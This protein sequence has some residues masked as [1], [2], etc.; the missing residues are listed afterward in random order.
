MK[1]SLA[2]ISLLGLCACAT[3]TDN[4]NGLTMLTQEPTD[5]QFLYTLDSV[6][7]TYKI[8]DAYAYIEKSI[9]ENQV[10]FGDSYLIVNEDVTD[11]PGAIF[12]PEHTFKFKVKVYK[13]NK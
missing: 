10:Y 4:G 5:C 6:S 7:T 3:T 9:L 11:N 8:E 1:K 2:L 13:C 12:A